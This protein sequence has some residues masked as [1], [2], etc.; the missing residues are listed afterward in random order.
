MSAVARHWATRCAGLLLEHGIAMAQGHAAIARVT[1]VALQDQRIPELLHELIADLL[2]EWEHLAIR[3]EALTGKQQAQAREDAKAHQLMSTRG[4]G[5]IIATALI[6]KQTQPQRFKNAR[7]FAAYFDAVPNQNSSGEKVRLGKMSKRGDGYLRGL[8]I[9]GAHAVLSQ[10]DPASQ[11]P[12]DRRLLRW[13]QRY[14]RKG[15]A[16][17]LV[18]R[19]FRIVW[20]TLTTGQTVAHRCLPTYWP[21]RPIRNWHCAS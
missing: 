12:D 3:I 20:V 11:Q 5:P 1:P 13:I 18:N 19:N 15:A 2:T 8:M 14:G 4:I 7:M 17:R 21:T 9:E 6:A 16:I 10:L